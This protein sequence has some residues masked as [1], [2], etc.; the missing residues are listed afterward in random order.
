MTDTGRG[1][2]RSDK[3]N[4]PPRDRGRTG[5]TEEGDVVGDEVEMTEIN[6]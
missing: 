1:S 4:H 3:V 5:A 6:F 2:R